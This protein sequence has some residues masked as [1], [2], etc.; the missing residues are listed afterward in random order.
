MDMIDIK[1]PTDI[2]DWKM[3]YYERPEKRTRTKLSMDTHPSRLP[4][5]KKY[6]DGK[7]A[8]A[9]MESILNTARV[10]PQVAISQEFKR[11]THQKERY[12][13]E[14]YVTCLEMISLLEGGYTHHLK[15]PHGETNSGVTKRVYEDFGEQKT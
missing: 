6:R 4:S 13:T 9:A 11:R 12:M 15:D 10:P 1:N 8:A 2:D 14:N 3:V 5:P 7:I